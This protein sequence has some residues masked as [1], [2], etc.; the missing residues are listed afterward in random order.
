MLFLFYYAVILILLLCHSERS[1]E[2]QRCL[3][4]FD[5]TLLLCAVF[6]QCHSEVQSDEQSRNLNC[7]ISL[8]TFSNLWYYFNMKISSAKFVTSVAKVSNI[9]N[10]YKE[11]AFVGRSNVGKSSLINSL[12]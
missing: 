2:S 6:T 3:A 9:P 1:K 11:F 12:L 7:K 10:D 5:M 4:S 8:E